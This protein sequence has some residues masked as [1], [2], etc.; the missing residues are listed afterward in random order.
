MQV[1]VWI[2]T[3][4]KTVGYWSRRAVVQVTDNMADAKSWGEGANTSMVR[5]RI[6]LRDTLTALGLR[7]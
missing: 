2:N 7:S 5:A 6:L 1:Q 4:T 3:M